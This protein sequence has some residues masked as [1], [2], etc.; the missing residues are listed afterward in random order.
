MFNEHFYSIIP[1]MC[2]YFIT[3]FNFFTLAPTYKSI[4]EVN[5]IISNNNN[6]ESSKLFINEFDLSK[7]KNYE[8]II[9]LENLENLNT[10]DNFTNI[11]EY[12]NIINII[13][14]Y[15]INKDIHKDITYFDKYK[16]IMASPSMTGG[17]GGGNNNNNNNY[18]Y[19]K[20]L[21]YKQKYIELKNSLL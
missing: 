2:N 9:S 17:G 7:F 14:N 5:D 16:M 1:N 4:I 11:L 20:Y 13:N 6:I 10:L 3:V 12:V 18:N 21:K 19:K 8:K 15:I